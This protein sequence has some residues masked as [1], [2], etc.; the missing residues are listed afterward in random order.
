MLAYNVSGWGLWKIFAT[1]IVFVF[2]YRVHLV[3]FIVLII[4]GFSKKK[5]RD[6][7]QSKLLDPADFNFIILAQKAAKMLAHF[8][9]I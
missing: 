8:S 5:N 7:N 2:W 4:F 9:R 6:N 1:V 3:P